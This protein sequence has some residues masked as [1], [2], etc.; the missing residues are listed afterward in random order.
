MTHN[1]YKSDAY[2]LGLTF[3]PM[4]NLVEPKELMNLEAN[5]E[6]KVSRVQCSDRVKAMLRSMFTVR[7]ECP[8][9]T[10]SS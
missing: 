5:A 1:Q 4:V 3:M 8:A 6:L 10:I 2:F 9:Q 7:E